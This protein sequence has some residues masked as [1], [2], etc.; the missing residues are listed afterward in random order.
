MLRKK[1]NMSQENSCKRGKL[2]NNGSC[3]SSHA[4]VHISDCYMLDVNNNII[5]IY[6]YNKKTLRIFQMIHCKYKY[7]EKIIIEN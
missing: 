7:N 1:N 4:I 5:G 2:E 6:V 3:V